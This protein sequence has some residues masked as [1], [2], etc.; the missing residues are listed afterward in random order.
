MPFNNNLL[1]LNESCVWNNLGARVF[2]WCEPSN[3]QRQTHIIT[4]KYTKRHM[5][6]DFT[7]PQYPK[8]PIFMSYTIQ[9]IWS[10]RISWIFVGQTRHK[11]THTQQAMCSYRTPFNLVNAQFMRIDLCIF[12]IRQATGNFSVFT[13]EGWSVCIIFLAKKDK[14]YS[15]YRG[16]RV[17]WLFELVVLP[18]SILCKSLIHCRPFHDNGTLKFS[19]RR[20]VEYNERC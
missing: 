7:A 16:S 4:R 17:F 11:H 6:D 2:I 9:Y 14:S 15:V 19:L 12:H 13:E 5:K 20:I 8:Q 3:R 10:V 18:T 1:G